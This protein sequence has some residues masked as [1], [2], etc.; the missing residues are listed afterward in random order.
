[1]T[2]AGM[3]AAFEAATVAAQSTTARGDALADYIAQI[4]EQLDG[5]TLYQKGVWSD[6]HSQELDV[7]LWNEKVPSDAGIDFL[8]HILLVEA[9]NWERRVGSAEVAWFKEKVRVGGDE[10][11]GYMLGILVAPKGITG[12]DG[13]SDDHKFAVQIIL[14]ARAERIRLLVLTPEEIAVDAAGLRLLIRDRMMALVA[15]RAGIG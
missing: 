8:S 1:M 2:P 7:M 3:F 12:Q 10:S 4:F 14:N 11:D 6:D 15:G 5:V 9:K 13:P